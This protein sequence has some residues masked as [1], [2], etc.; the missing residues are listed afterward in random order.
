VANNQFSLK[1]MLDLHWVLLP[2]FIRQRLSAKADSLGVLP[3]KL[4]GPL[5]QALLL[6]PERQE[7]LFQRAGN[8][9]DHIESGAP[10]WGDWPT[11]AA[12]ALCVGTILG[13][14]IETGVEQKILELSEED[15]A[16][17]DK[18]CQSE[19]L[20]LEQYV[21]GLITERLDGSDESEE[22]RNQ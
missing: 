4:A 5:I 3:L 6:D 9:L 16:R 2:P 20:S 13:M 10:G 8:I 7:R 15:L 11:D 19:G 22:W 14:W 17:A 18:R 1:A 12:D 21:I